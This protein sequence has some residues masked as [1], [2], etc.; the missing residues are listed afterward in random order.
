M[1]PGLVILF[2]ILDSGFW[3]WERVA[4]WADVLLQDT[5]QPQSWLIELSMAGSLPA[6]LE[7]VRGELARRQLV[8][9]PEVGALLAGFVYCAFEDGKVDSSRMVK[10]LVD[11]CDAYDVS[12]IALSELRDLEAPEG[13][14]ERVRCESLRES[15]HALAATS[16]SCASYLESDDLRRREP[17]LIEQ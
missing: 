6:A 17:N 14:M 16:R 9:P 3:C 2:A 5:N 7:V 1:P 13:S 4:S 12:G 11:C 15:M 10:E 8:L